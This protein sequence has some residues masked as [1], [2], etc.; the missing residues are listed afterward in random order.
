MNLRPLSVPVTPLLTAAALLAFVVATARVLLPFVAAGLLAAVLVMTSWPLFR[1]LRD[2]LRSPGWA[3]ALMTV[4]MLLVVVGPLATAVQWV[5]QSGPGWVEQLQGWIER[6]V[7]APPAW[8]A[9]VPLIGEVTAERWAAAVD[10]PG[11]LRQFGLQLLEMGREPLLSG[12]RLVG[13]GLLQLLTATFLAFFLWRDGAELVARLQKTLGQLCGDAAREI[14]GLVYA[15]VNSVMIGVVGTGLAQGAIAGVGFA[16]AGVPGPVLLGA[17]T[18]VVSIL[19]SGT[20]PIWAGA[21][22]WLAFTGEPGWAVFMVAWG[23]LLVSTIDNVLRPIIISRGGGLSFLPVFLGM[24]GGTFAFGF[25]GLF[26]GP[27]LLAV[28]F[29]LWQ[30]WVGE[31]RPEAMPDAG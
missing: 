30:H 16:I 26:V 2:R 25:V 8:L 10:D 9:Q 23:L 19:P 31:R 20:V 5:V 11:V 4:L 14:P 22:L 12:G 13:S 28:A 7:P 6:G 3:A 27:T 1:R 15:T 29:R 21:A 18:A 17:L 24:V